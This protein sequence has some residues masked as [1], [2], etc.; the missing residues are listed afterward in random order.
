MDIEFESSRT[1]LVWDVE[2]AAEN[3]AKHGV[4]FTEAVAVFTDPEFVLTDVARN[5]ESRHK[6]IGFSSTGKL[7]AVVHTEADG[8]FIRIISAW[9][10]TAA[11]S[12]LYD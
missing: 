12:H 4:E 9:Q 3:F 8:E 5:G 1:L 11:E 2:K 6:A 10:A 7:L